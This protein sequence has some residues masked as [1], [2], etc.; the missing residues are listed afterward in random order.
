MRS[1]FTFL[2]FLFIGL[3]VRK[4][5]VNAAEPYI[6][7]R[8]SSYHT[9]AHTNGQISEHQSKSPSLPRPASIGQR[10]MGK[11]HASRLYWDGL[12]IYIYMLFIV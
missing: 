9:A 10:I 4:A 3:C 12:D 11:H 8:G 5:S 6:G 2:L 1:P 7:A